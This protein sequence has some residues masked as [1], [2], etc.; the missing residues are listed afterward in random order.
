MFKASLTF[1]P[2][3]GVVPFFKTFLLFSSWALTSLY[4]LSVI[5][6][7][8]ELQ[9]LTVFANVIS[10]NFPD[11]VFVSGVTIIDIAHSM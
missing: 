4:A 8:D 5:K 6:A 7:L 9:L 2:K 11:S 1:P 3:N 10:L